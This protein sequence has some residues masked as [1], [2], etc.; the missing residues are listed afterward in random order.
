MRENGL[1]RR[2]VGGTAAVGHDAAGG[3]PGEAAPDRAG[4]PSGAARRRRIVLA[5]A[6]VAALV[7]VGGLAA[8]PL[9]RSPAERA[10]QTAPPAR[11]LL[12]AAA[13]MRVLSPSVVIRGTVYPPTQY[14]VSAGPAAA[15]VTQL[16]VSRLNVR[17]GD[18][19][20]NGRLLA[21]VSGQPLFVLAGP[22][23]AY[24][25]L[26]PGGTG[27]DVG[28][29]QDAL[30]ALGHSTGS[31]PRSTFGAGTA[32]AVDAFYRG[33]GYPVPTTG[34]ATQQAVDAAGKAVEADQRT[35]D[36]LAAQRRAATGPPAGPT[37][38]AAPPAP[39]TPAA[40]PGSAQPVPPVPPVLAAPAVP[41]GLSLDQQLTT[42]RKQLADD[43][44]ALA[45]AV[46]VNGPMVPAAHVVFLPALPAAVTAVNGSVGAPAAG[47]LLSLTSGGL[48]LTG[49]LAPAQ[50]AAV[51]PGMAVEVFSEATGTTVAGT[52]AELGAQTTAP[53]AGRVIP[54]G[55][56]PGSAAGAV[57]AAGPGNGTPAGPPYVPLAVTPSTP[58]PATLN[59]QNVRMT[60]REDDSTEPVLSVPV[61]AV[62]TT[63]AGRTSV[64]RVDADGGRSTVAVTVGAS[65]D[66][67]VG[68]TPDGAALRA[69]DPVVV[70]R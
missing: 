21:E 45:R 49:L 63:S 56:A 68:V 3:S 42:A 43:R 54:I 11:T 30:A 29:L 27:P 41:G 2:E 40:P 46:A 51:R 69:G 39:S 16:Y 22:V 4:G 66:G 38:P 15:D 58:L 19:V 34:A 13:T 31:D 28:E 36:A 12:T 8:A 20:G 57:G 26:K 70:G 61:A 67:F 25:D 35:V 24:R 44:A 64:T 7:P 48:S 14:N 1:L 53:P 33:L 50:A 18:E 47:P 5:V 52:V 9:I 62:F 17:T 37:T 32:Q 60:V 10:A 6:T 65:A 59:G 23:P 55:G